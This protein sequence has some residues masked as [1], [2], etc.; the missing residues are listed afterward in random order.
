M[1]AEEVGITAKT[2]WEEGAEQPMVAMATTGEAV[3][4]EE[5]VT[6][7]RQVDIKSKVMEVEATTVVIMLGVL[8]ATAVG[9]LTVD[10]VLQREPEEGLWLVGGAVVV[11]AATA[12]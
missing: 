5:A 6:E 11:A 8:A 3:M 9:T 4:V 7:V 12:L 10:M 2:T 1:P